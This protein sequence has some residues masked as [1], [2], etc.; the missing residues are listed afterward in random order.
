[1]TALPPPNLPLSAGP[2]EWAVCKLTHRGLQG[3]RVCE[4]G[5]PG[6]SQLSP[7]LQQMFQISK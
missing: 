7:A 2:R 4:P 3:R 6:E 1:M 5:V